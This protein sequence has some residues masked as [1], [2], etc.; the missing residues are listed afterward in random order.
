LDT[1]RREPL[2]SFIRHRQKIQVLGTSVNLRDS[3]Q[4]KLFSQTFSLL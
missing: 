3:G 2:E 1:A 4:K